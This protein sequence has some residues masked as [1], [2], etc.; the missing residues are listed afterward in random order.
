MSKILLTGPSGF[1]GQ[2]LAW[3]LTSE[4]HQLR[5]AIRSPLPWQPDETNVFHFQ[6]LE[7][8]TNWMDALSGI[9]VLVHCAGRAQVVN[10]SAANPLA[11]YRR[12]NVDGVVR[13][14]SQAARAGVRRFVFL[15]TIKVC[16][17]QSLPG[18]PFSIDSVPAPAS[19]YAISK[20]EA[21]LAL[22]SLTASS[23]MEIVIVRPPLVYGPG[24]KGNFLRMMAW[25]ARGRPLP[26]AGGSYCKRSLVSRSNLVD[27]LARCVHHPAAG[28]HILHVSDGEDLTV[29]DLFRRLGAALGKPARLIRVPGCLLKGGLTLL[30]RRKMFDQLYTPL[31]VNIS[32]TRQLLDWTPPYA[33]EDALAQ[34]AAH[35]HKHW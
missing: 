27:L 13:L 32:H 16:G 35:F 4:G 17:E 5:L 7:A 18:Q 11:A 22:F 21:E 12:C 25:I 14:A 30:G 24:V 20:H 33:V 19:P 23:G 26:L 31:E 10:E 1:I 28:G 15:S 6:G 34:T 3:R 29:S 2:A 9:E 8:P